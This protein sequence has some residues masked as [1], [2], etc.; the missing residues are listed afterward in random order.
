MNVVHLIGNLTKDLELRYTPGTNK[1]VA[2]GSI[3]V[4]RKRKGADGKYPS[5]FFNIVIWGVIGENAVKYNGSKGDKIGITGR[6][7]NRSYEAKD[8]TKRYITEII[9]EE[10]EYLK[11]NRNGASDSSENIPSDYFGGG[12][13]TPIEDGEDM[14][15]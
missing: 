4:Q 1:A 15:F 2:T 10:V 14:P 8:G 9:A 12:D 11:V 5:D 7:E 13:M 6:I 3:A